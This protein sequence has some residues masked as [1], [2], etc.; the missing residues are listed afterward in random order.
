MILK[1]YIIL[2][3]L[4]DVSCS[5][6]NANSKSDLRLVPLLKHDEAASLD[7]ILNRVGSPCPQALQPSLPSEQKRLR[8]I[9]G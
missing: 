5:D 9:R 6:E 8:L 4:S 7:G 3:R 2:S 1:K